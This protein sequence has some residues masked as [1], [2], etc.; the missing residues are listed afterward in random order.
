MIANHQAAYCTD[1][2]LKALQSVLTRDCR[3]PWRWS[4]FPSSQARLDSPAG[5]F[6]RFG[7]P[8]II[9]VAPKGG[10]SRG[11][12]LLCPYGGNLS[13]AQEAIKDFVIAKGVSHVVARDLDGVLA[14]LSRCGCIP[15]WAAALKRGA[16]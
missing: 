3:S 8:A 6:V 11:I 4:V 12:E 14:A 1:A 16:A 5:R 9:I 7:L 13:R 2:S 15:I 10:R